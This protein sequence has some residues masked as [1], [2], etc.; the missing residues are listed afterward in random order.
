MYPAH[1][2]RHALSF[3]EKGDDIDS[4]SHALNLHASVL[5]Q[6][7]ARYDGMTMAQIVACQ[8]MASRQIEKAALLSRNR[9]NA[10][11][12]EVNK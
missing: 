11:F 7:Q 12:S 3:L 9:Y 5:R 10:L 2:I 4:V 1:L 8:S 6:W